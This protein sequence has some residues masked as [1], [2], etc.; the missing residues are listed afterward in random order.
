MRRFFFLLAALA[1]PYMQPAFSQES[2]IYGSWRIDNI[3]YT[4]DKDSLYIDDDV[5]GFAYLFHRDMRDLYK[6]T[7]DSNVNGVTGTIRILYLDRVKMVAKFICDGAEDVNAVLFRVPDYNYY[8]HYA[9]DADYKSTASQ[10]PDDAK[11]V[12]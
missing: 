10:E 5:E 1:F 2:G 9:K 6:I 7:Y 4:F 12:K 8:L 3:V 11:D